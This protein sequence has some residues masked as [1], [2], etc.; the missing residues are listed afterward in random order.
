MASK[1]GWNPYLAGILTGL[2]VV[3]SAVVS[4]QLLG[5]SQC[6]DASGAFVWIAALLE[7][8]TVPEHAAR[9]EYFQQ[10]GALW[11]VM[12]VVGIFG[13]AL[14][15]AFREGGFKR[16]SVPPMWSGRFGENAWLRGLV[17]FG[18]GFLAM[19][20]ALLAGGCLIGCGLGDVMQLSLEG[21][22]ALVLFLIAGVLTARFLYGGRDYPWR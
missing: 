9:Q 10:G 19:F 1:K 11:Q 17:A 3:G 14:L 22:V 8:L 12:F 4:A 7:R 2:V 18:G 13:G 6:P 5:K 21:L 16:E 15:A 20:G